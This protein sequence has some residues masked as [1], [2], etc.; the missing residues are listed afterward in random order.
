MTATIEYRV[1]STH[2][3]TPDKGVEDGASSVRWLDQ[4]GQAGDR[5]QPHRRPR[6][7]VGELLRDAGYGPAFDSPDEDK[8]VSS[9]PDALVL[10]YPHL[11]WPSDTVSKTPEDAANLKKLTVVFENWR[12]KEKG[13]PAIMFLGTQ[14]AI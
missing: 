13:P 3:T 11:G 8:S 6:G 12:S 4:R 7:F 2:H 1:S 10:F 9:K 5:S 14:P